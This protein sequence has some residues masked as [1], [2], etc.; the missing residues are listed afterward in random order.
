MRS[1]EFSVVASRFVTAAASRSL[2]PSSPRRRRAPKSSA[3]TSRAWGGCRPFRT[4]PWPSG[5]L[6]FIAGTLGIEPGAR[7]IGRPAVSRAQTK[8]AL[9]NIDRILDAARTDR[10]NVLQCTVYL[11]DMTQFAEMNEAW[12]PFFGGS[13]RR[14]RPS[15]SRRSRSTPRSRSSASRN[16]RWRPRG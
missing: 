13:R 3:S 7:E 2:R 8:Q 9:E 5:Q 12:M 6:V 14:E 11:T 4:P 10:G 15:A 1:L 16:A